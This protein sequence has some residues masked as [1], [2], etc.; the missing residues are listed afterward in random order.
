MKNPCGIKCRYK[1]TSNFNSGDREQTFHTF[2]QLADIKKKRK[3]RR[4]FI[5]MYSEK[6]IKKSKTGQYERRKYAIS[7]FLP[8]LNETGKKVCNTFFLNTLSISDKLAITAHTKIY[9]LGICNDD[10]RSK[11]KKDQIK[12]RRHTK[13]MF[14]DI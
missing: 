11:H 4:Q 6:K 7:W 8:C 13:C 5:L 9:N 3:K 2:W 1:C 14:A 12:P 10:R